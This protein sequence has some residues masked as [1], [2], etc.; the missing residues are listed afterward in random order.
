MSLSR[1]RISGYSQIVKKVEE[2]LCYD[3]CVF[4]VSYTSLDREFHS[5]VFKNATSYKMQW[6]LN[7][8]ITLNV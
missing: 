5:I 6:N 4:H 2:P 8:I 3:L 1:N 7:E